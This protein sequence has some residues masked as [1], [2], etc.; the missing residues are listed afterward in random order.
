MPEAGRVTQANDIAKP[1][2]MTSRTVGRGTPG[3]A[4][5]VSETRASVCWM[6]PP[7]RTS[8]PAPSEP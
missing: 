2:I 6:K 7:P 5:A 1:G 3:Q 4:T 8:A